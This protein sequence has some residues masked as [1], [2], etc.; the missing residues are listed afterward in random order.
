V[1]DVSPFPAG[2]I[3]YSVLLPVDFSKRLKTCGTPQVIGIRAVLSWATPPS[4][5][6]PNDLKTWGNRIDAKVLLRK[7]GT[8]GGLV[9]Q[10]YDI[11][12][13]PLVNISNA[14]FLAFPSPASTGPGSNRPWGGLVRIG[15]RIQGAGTP[16][17]VWFKVEFANHAV[18][19]WQPVTTGETF[20]MMYPLDF[21]NPQHDTPVVAINGW[22]E[23]LEDFT[24]FPAIFERTAKLSTWNTNA[25]TDGS[26]DLRLAYTQD[27]PNLGNPTNIA[28]SLTKTVVINNTGFSVSPTAN[29]T[30]DF[31]STLDLVITGGDCHKYSKAN[32]EIINGALRVVHPYF[33]SWDLDLQPTTHTHGI[34]PSPQ[35]RA[36]VLPV[37]TGD[38]NAAWTLAVGGLDACGYTI[39]LRGYDRTIINS[40]GA[41]VHSAAKA[42]GFSVF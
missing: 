16:P 12:N 35:S 7:L 32:N 1:H 17:S 11:G 6:D 5:T 29:A 19:N 8:S 36:F 18:N 30:L 23:Y 14:T 15:G 9:E 10:L 40:N 39:T 13:V 38:A 37:D 41:I 3:D 24:A 4:T 26:Y 34:T 33:G 28:Y 42:L 27:D 21:F 20:E 25:L 31:G 22:L 2:G